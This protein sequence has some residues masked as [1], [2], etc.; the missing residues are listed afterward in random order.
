MLKSQ[1]AVDEREKL[2][3]AMTEEETEESEESVE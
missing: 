3:E 2:P 1:Q